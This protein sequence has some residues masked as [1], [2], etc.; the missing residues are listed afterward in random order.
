M[1]LSRLW[2]FPARGLHDICVDANDTIYASVGCG[3]AGRLWVWKC[4]GEDV[5]WI[6]RGPETPLDWN[7]AMM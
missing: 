3:H 5:S 6:K 1:G 4:D 7:Q 2:E